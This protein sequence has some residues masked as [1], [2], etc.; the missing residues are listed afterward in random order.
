LNLALGEWAERAL[1]SFHLARGSRDKL[2]VSSTLLETYA[3]LHWP[4][5]GQ[6]GNFFGH[7]FV[8]RAPDQGSARRAL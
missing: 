8:A 6:V 5:A 2:K 4:S 3:A 1:V 7:L